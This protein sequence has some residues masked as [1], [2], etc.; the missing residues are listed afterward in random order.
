MK[1][2]MFDVLEKTPEGIDE[3]TLDPA[4]K[5]DPEDVMEGVHRKLSADKKKG[6]RSTMKKSKRKAPII[7][8]AALISV[9]AVGTLTVGALGG[10]NSFIGE[11]SAGK[12][13]NNLYPGSDVNVSTES[14]MKGEFLGITGDDTN[15]VSLVRLTNADGSDII[16][17]GKD[18]FIESSDY[19]NYYDNT[20]K[21]FEEEVADIDPD[22]ESSELMNPKIKKTMIWHTV[23]H[24]ITDATEYDED[25]TA[26]ISH[27]IWFRDPFD[28][29]YPCFVSYEMA[30]SK[31][32]NCYLS[33]Y[34]DSGLFQ[35]LKG[36]TLRAEDKNLYIYQIDKVLYKSDTMDD[37][38][39]FELDHDRFNGVITD[40]IKSLRD[41]QV[42]TVHGYSMVIATRKEINIDLD[43]SAKLNYKSNVK[44]LPAA[45]TTL[46]GENGTDFK[47]A[48]INAGSLST[49]VEL[50]YTLPEGKDDYDTFAGLI[51]VYERSAKITL[52]NGKVLS[53]QYSINHN[54]EEKHV[55][56]LTYF[57]SEDE[58]VSSWVIIN[59]E[60]IK[61]ITFMGTEITK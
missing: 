47:V 58:N 10:I 29:P 19:R 55:V 61:S 40:N 18:S 32:I 28:T 24:D 20:C 56:T 8:A 49:D 36:E 39:R 4:Y 43:V 60:E 14:S 21:Q 54:Y 3:S 9:L 7:L 34:I 26:K 25:P 48:R 5:I 57:D 31:T 51:P 35:S 11:H 23:G 17:A 13:V 53:A 42:I 6:G 45:D 46:R 44:E 22:A 1:K 59:P 27:S 38:V 12:M 15:M 30:D 50:D 41:D 37:F 16:E 33:S 2:T 52:T